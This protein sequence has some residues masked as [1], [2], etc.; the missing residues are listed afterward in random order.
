VFPAFDSP[1]FG[2]LRRVSVIVGKYLVDDLLGA[3]R[4]LLMDE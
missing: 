1:Y 4:L 2:R 3:P